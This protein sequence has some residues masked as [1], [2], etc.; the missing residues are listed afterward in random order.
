MLVLPEPLLISSA[1]K[2]LYLTPTPPDRQTQCQSRPFETA[3]VPLLSETIALPSSGRL[4][5]PMFIPTASQKS[6]SRGAAPPLTRSTL[7]EPES[8]S[9]AMLLEATSEKQTSFQSDHPE[10]PRPPSTLPVPTTSICSHPNRKPGGA[11][12]PSFLHRILRN[13]VCP[14]L[15]P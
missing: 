10:G 9:D 2:P 12:G 15:T 3:G 8:V 7:Q 6:I 14:T 5:T 11:S 13:D 4:L 1:Q